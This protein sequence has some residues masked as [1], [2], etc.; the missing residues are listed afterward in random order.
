MGKT[1]DIV[2]A[3]FPINCRYNF[4]VEPNGKCYSSEC[5]MNQDPELKLKIKKN[6]CKCFEMPEVQSI[7]KE[8]DEG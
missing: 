3:L 5:M 8:K 2:K 6:G 1:L 4:K 7:L